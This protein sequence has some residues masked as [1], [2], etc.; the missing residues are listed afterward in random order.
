[1]LSLLHS[2]MLGKP[3]ERKVLHNGEH[4]G[5]ELNLVAVKYPQL[6]LKQEDSLTGPQT[7]LSGTWREM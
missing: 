7:L 2:E 5:I 4:N 3:R 1:M 6:S